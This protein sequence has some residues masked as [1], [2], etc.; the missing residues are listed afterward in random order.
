VHMAA[1]NMIPKPAVK[2]DRRDSIRLGHLFQSGS[3]P[4]CYIPPPEIEHLRLFTRN[5]KDLAHKVTLVKNQ[6]HALVTRNLLDSEMKGVSNIFGVTGLH[7]LARLPLRPEERAHLARCLEQLELLAQQ[8]EVMQVELAKIA[9]GR[10]DVQF[11]M[12]IPGVGFYTAIGILAEI[13]NIKRFPDK[14]HLA[15]YAGLVP[16]ADNSGDKVSAGRPVKKG[17]LQLKSFLCTAVKG[18]LKSGQTTAVTR[19]YRKKAESQPAQKATVDAARKLSG[20]IWKILTFEVPYREEDA[21][22]TER[23]EK[24]MNEVAEELAPAISSEDLAALAGRLSGKT[25]VLDRL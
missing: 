18:M 7:K 3:M 5:R 17:N 12:T 2:T 19:F 22:L 6:V 4:E 13:G 8:E 14:Q 25:D 1:P 20:E 11:L 10:K 23:K 16:K 15:S 9:Q 21:D 24:R